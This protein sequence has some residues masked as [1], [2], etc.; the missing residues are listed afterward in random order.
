MILGW[1]GLLPNDFRLEGGVFGRF[2]AVFAS[3]FGTGGC[4]D[5]IFFFAGVGLGVHP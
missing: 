5:D 1:R 4:S 2:A 3:F